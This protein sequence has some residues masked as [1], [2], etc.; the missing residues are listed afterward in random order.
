[1]SQS[2]SLKLRLGNEP[3]Q[4][5]PKLLEENKE[6]IEKSCSYLLNMIET[7]YEEY[8]KANELE[9][10]A[11]K[12]AEELII[13][14]RI[15]YI[16]EFGFEFTLNNLCIP[17][18]V[19]DRLLRKLGQRDYHYQAGQAIFLEHELDKSFNE[20]KE[21]EFLRLTIFI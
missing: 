10:I 20:I 15:V 1:M 2:W 13:W 8:V 9:I 19:V 11:K 4:D 14:E 16:K 3:Q 17:G 6:I 12:L 5:I 7:E 18:K 21:C